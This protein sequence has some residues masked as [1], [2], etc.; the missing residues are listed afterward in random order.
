MIARG[1]SFMLKQVQEQNGISLR[2]IHQEVRDS[3]ASAHTTVF[4]RVEMSFGR[5]AANIRSSGVGASADNRN[6]YWD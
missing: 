4:T 3:R 2:P 5:H 1:F 6:Q